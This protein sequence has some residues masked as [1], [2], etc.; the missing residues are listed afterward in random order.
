M[1][2]FNFPG[3]IYFEEL[4]IYIHVL[5]IYIL[6]DKMYGYKEMLLYFP[7]TLQNDTGL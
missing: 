6:V 2:M 1:Y 5:D 7:G 3:Y 4:G